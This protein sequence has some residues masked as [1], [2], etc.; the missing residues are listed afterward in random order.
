MCGNGWLAAE[1]IFRRTGKSIKVINLPF[2]N[3][4][5]AGWLAGVI[6][7][8]PAIFTLDNHYVEGGQGQK[9][10]ATALMAGWQGKAHM[11]G[12][13]DVPPGGAADEVLQAVGLDVK[14]IAASMSA[15]L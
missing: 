10:L 8:Q 11:M 5:D 1:E 13:H 4:I 9:I 2:L 6:A 3:R 15:N 12:L 7:G 14:G